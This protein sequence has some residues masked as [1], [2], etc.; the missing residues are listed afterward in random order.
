VSIDGKSWGTKA[1]FS[2]TTVVNRKDYGINW[3]KVLDNGGT[4]VDD[5]V[6]IILNIEASKTR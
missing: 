4:M 3:N 5:M 2:A 6:T 1:G